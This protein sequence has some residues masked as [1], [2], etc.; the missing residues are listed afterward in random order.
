[1]KSNVEEMSSLLHD[2]VERTQSFDDRMRTRRMRKLHPMMLDELMHISLSEGIGYVGVQMALGLLKGQYPWIYDTG[3]ETIKI[4]R[5][6]RGKE[7][8]HRAL[9][10]FKRVMS[11][12]STIQ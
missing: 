6:R 7:E 11:F 12:Q 4:L 2:V 1:M 10:Q 5:S 3:I 8:K 9:D